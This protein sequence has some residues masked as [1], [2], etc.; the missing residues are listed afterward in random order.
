MGLLRDRLLPWWRDIPP[1]RA[2][3]ILVLLI[4]LLRENIAMPS[5]KLGDCYNGA[6]KSQ[7]LR[8][9]AIELRYNENEEI[10]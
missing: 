7:L 6:E 3:P 4:G 1:L 2:P 9:I 8:W 5:E 10:A